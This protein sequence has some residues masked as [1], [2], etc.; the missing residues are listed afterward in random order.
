MITL[1]FSWWWIPIICIVVFGIVVCC[2]L[3]E[4]DN[5]GIG[6]AF[7]CLILVI[8]IAIALLIGGIVIW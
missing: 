2:R 7:G 1:T 3:S 4:K 5:Y 6:A 8:C